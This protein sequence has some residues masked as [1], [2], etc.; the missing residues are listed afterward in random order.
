MWEILSVTPTVPGQ[1]KVIARQGNRVIHQ[2]RV[3]EGEVDAVDFD[4]IW[5]NSMSVRKR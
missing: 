2:D 4:Q 3:P 1:V 5:A